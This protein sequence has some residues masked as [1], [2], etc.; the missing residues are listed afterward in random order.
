MNS[1]F[2]ICLIVASTTIIQAC[3][4]ESLP[5]PSCR[6]NANY[7]SNQQGQGACIVRLNNRLLATKR[8]SGLYNLPIS[9]SISN[10]SAQCSAH[11]EMWRQTGLNI[12][13]EK[14][15]GIQANGTWLFGCK[16]E[17]GFDGTEPPF[18]PPPWVE[19]E[20]EQLEFVEPFKLELDNWHHPD[21]FI[22]VRDGF[23]AQGHY[24]QETQQNVNQQTLQEQN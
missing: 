21:Q 7:M 14:V 15:V 4:N 18:P 2:K 11:Y 3:T 5:E 9:E 22:V 13:V 24:Q 23:V 19:S 16:L 12:E 8:S 6:V 17:A 1:G 20:I 10:K